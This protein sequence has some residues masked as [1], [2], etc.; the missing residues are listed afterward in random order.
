[1]LLLYGNDFWFPEAERS[2]EDV[3]PHA[4]QDASEVPMNI[5]VVMKI[6]NG[7]ASETLPHRVLPGASH[8]AN[9]KDAV[10]MQLLLGICKRHDLLFPASNAGTLVDTTVDGSAH[11]ISVKNSRAVA[12]RLGTPA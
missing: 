9:A 2:G 7:L 12:R 3:G 6:E 1:M 5:H 4:R 8:R 10:E 11:M